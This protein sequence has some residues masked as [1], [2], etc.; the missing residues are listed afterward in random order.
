MSWIFSW[1]MSQICANDECQSQVGTTNRLENI[2]IRY[3][4]LGYLYVFEFES[5]RPF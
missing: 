3:I 2:V 4:S 1:A 5:S